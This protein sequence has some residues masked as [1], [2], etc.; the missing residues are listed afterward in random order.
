MPLTFWKTWKVVA[1]FGL[2]TWFIFSGCPGGMAVAQEAEILSTEVSEDQMAEEPQDNAALVSSIL[3]GKGQEFTPEEQH[4]MMINESLKNAVEENRN[5]TQDNKAMEETL[6]GLREKSGL[7]AQRVTFLSNERDTMQRHIANMENENKEY[8]EQLERLKADMAEKE[9][10][11]SAKLTDIE[12]E[13]TQKKEQ[14][15]GAMAAVLPGLPGK[16]GTG[17]KSLSDLRS[18]AKMTMDKVEEDA[19]KAAARASQVTQENK[20]LKIDSAKLHYN[21]ANTLFEQGKYRQAAAEYE[22]VVEMMPGDPEAHYNLAFVSGE[23]L[24]DRITALEHYQQ[25]LSLSP[26]A[27]DKSLVVEKILEIRLRMET[28][29]SSPIDKPSGFGLDHQ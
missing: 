25:Y 14:D 10:E 16:T 6:K 17:E 7:N 9:K 27:D 28:E 8:K 5:L 19:K 11:F 23:F 24:E 29:I 15:E 21:L 18:K 13:E 2:S 3:Q 22:K 1:F 26:D 12:R 4:L 20:K